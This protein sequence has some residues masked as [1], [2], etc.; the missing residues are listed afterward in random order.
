M[1]SLR[2][3]TRLLVDSCVLRRGMVWALESCISALHFVCCE[4]V[5]EAN[6]SIRLIKTILVWR[7]VLH[8]G[9]INWHIWACSLS[10]VSR[11]LTQSTSILPRGNICWAYTCARAKHPRREP[12][13]KLSVL[14]LNSMDYFGP[15]WS[16]E[17][18]LSIL[19]GSG[20]LIKIHP[21]F[22]RLQKLWVM[23]GTVTLC[24]WLVKVLTRVA[25]AGVRGSQGAQV[26]SIL[27]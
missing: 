14:I 21:L 10:W 16:F 22:L 19:L 23:H 25:W 4:S 17:R 9:I 6:G 13:F 15:T 11:S 27:L 3:S 5:A 8:R 1:Q 2:E 24:R 26:V 20:S 12:R 18:T 7:I